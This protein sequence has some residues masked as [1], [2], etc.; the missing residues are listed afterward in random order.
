MS[1]KEGY[2]LGVMSRGFAPSFGLRSCRQENEEGNG[3]WYL[4]IYSTFLHTHPYEIPLK[5]IDDHL[6]LVSF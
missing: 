1:G 3:N 4:S 5:T 6:I 2:D